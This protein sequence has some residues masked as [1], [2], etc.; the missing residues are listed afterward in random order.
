MH[1]SV[2]IPTYNNAGTLAQAIQ[3]VLAQTYGEIDVVVVDDGSTDGTPEVMREFPGVRYLRQANGGLPAARNA[4]IAATRGE[5]IAFLDSDDW[6]EPEKIA[7]QVE[8]LRATPEVGLV[9]TDLR[10]IYDDGRVLE[11]FLA[12]RP[13]AGDGLVFDRLVQSGFILPSTVLLRREVL[14]QVGTFDESMRSHEDIELWLRVTRRW[15]VA[16]VR[17]A[18]TN[19]RQ[20]TG[21]MTANPY[22]RAEYSVRLCEKVLGHGGLSAEQERAVRRSLHERLFERAYYFLSVGEGAQARADLRRLLG[23][24]FKPKACAYLVASLLPPGALRALR[25]RRTGSS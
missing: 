9:Y 14:E 2:V 19:R 20:G 15:P 3:S 24:G 18:L 11:S 22:L 17:E 6:W 4:G 12:S 8:R 21:N 25:R 10:V 13:L 16:L 23:M 1:V 5:L 7:A